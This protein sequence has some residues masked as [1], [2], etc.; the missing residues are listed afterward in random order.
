MKLKNN[1]FLRC[2]RCGTIN[3][4]LVAEVIQEGPK[5]YIKTVHGDIY[6]VSRGEYREAKEYLENK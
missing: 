4:D 3:A 1:G 2:G 5:Y 6:E